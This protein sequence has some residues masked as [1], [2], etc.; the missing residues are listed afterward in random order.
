MISRYAHRRVLDDLAE[1]FLHSSIESSALEKRTQRAAEEHH[2]TREQGR[3]HGPDGTLWKW[4]D[5]SPRHSGRSS[6][7]WGN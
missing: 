6:V 5:Y 1:H 4:K 3:N 2:W 7:E